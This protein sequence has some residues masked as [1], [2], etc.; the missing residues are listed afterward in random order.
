M[1]AIVVV[2]ASNYGRLEVIVDSDAFWGVS[3][4]DGCGC[5]YPMAEVRTKKEMQFPPTVV[6]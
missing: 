2:G 1:S 5:G 3:H 6:E 4:G